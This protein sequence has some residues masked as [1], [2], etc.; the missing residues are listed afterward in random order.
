MARA[1]RG[2]K[3]RQRVKKVLESS[4]G[5]FDRRG[6]TIRRA[7]E[8]VDRS[9]VYAFRDRKRRKRVFRMMWIERI[10]AAAADNGISYSRLAFALAKSQ[11]GL[12]RKMLSEIAI[13]DPKAFTAIV[14]HVRS[15]APAA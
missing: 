11:V 2:A 10:S 3:R 6:N 12:N 4:K 9:R 7:S 13:H 8:A 5:F 1:K 14:D 15:A